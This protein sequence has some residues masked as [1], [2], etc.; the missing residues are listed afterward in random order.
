MLVACWMAGLTIA[1]A[2]LHRCSDRVA[3]A[4]RRGGDLGG[5]S[6]YERDDDL[7]ARLWRH[8]PDERRRAVSGR[9]RGRHRL[10]LLGRGDRVPARLVSGVLARETIISMLDARGR[11]APLGRSAAAVRAAQ[12][13]DLEAIRRLLQD[14]EQWSAEVLES[15]L[16]FP[17]LSYYRSQHDNQS[18]AGGAHRVAR[19]LRAFDRDGQRDSRITRPSSRLP[20]PDMRPSTWCWSF[21]CRRRPRAT[22]AWCRRRIEHLRAE[23]LKQGPSCTTKPR[24]RQFAELRAMYEPFLLALGGIFFSRSRPSIARPKRSTTGKPAPG[25][26]APPAS[27]SCTQRRRP[28]ITSRR[29]RP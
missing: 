7:H 17:V 14:L 27:A 8:G 15:H 2:C 21:M 11:L 9:R 25:C 4:R 10:R 5:V 16:S 18:W 24:P 3:L 20:C 6:L 12:S 13:H 23:L 1:F 22:T 19:C 28:T 26:G 29:I